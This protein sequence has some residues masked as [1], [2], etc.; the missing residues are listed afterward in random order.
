MTRRLIPT[1][2]AL[3]LCFAAFTPARAATLDMKIDAAKSAVKTAKEGLKKDKKDLKTIQKLRG[4]WEKAR[5][6]GN[7]KAEAKIDP[8]ITAWA[9]DK[10]AELRDNVQESVA[11][12]TAAGGIPP[13]EGAKP[14]VY[15]PGHEPPV[16]PS[17]YGPARQ[18]TPNA[19]AARKQVTLHNDRAA[20]DHLIEVTTSLADLQPRFTSGAAGP[21]AYQKK[22]HLL[23]ALQ[24]VAAKELA[25]SQRRLTA[26]EAKLAALKARK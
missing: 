22:S 26:D 23:Q 20:R 13:A 21:P 11:A 7:H 2:I 14:P 17:P 12:V 6:K 24:R 1:L 19:E 3:S 10:V 5:A 16:K 9:R 15:G 8:E 4:K 18:P 25:R